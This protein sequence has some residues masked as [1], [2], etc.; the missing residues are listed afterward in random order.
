MRIRIIT[1][2]FT[3]ALDGTACFAE[4]RWE[5]SVLVQP[6][7]IATAQVVSLD[8]D[9]REYTPTLDHDAVANAAHAWRDADVLTLQFDSTLR[10][11]VARDCSTALAAS[12]RRKLLIAPAFPSAGRT[13]EEGCVLVDGVPVHETAFGYD[14][15]LPVRESSIPALLRAHGIEVKVARDAAQARALLD[16]HDAVVVDARTEAELDAIATTFAGARDLL[17]AGSTGLLRGL[18]R[19]LPRPQ[20]APDDRGN[21]GDHAA[22][23]VPLA[24]RPWLVVGSLNPRSRRQLSI[25]QAQCRVNVLATGET[26]LP[27]SAPPQAALRDLVVQAVNVV[28]S[29]A[30]DGLV[31]TGGE[32]ARRII[33]ALPVVSLRVCREI[34]PGVPLAEVQTAIGTF[35]MITKA[36]GF[37]DDDA[38][39]TCIYALTGAQP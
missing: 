15:T 17:L 34:M 33:D 3:S 11:R 5:T 16:V 27:A 35:P 24:G 13:V 39:L 12:G 14:P 4:R 21:C 32:T 38:L 6:E 9:S 30:C 20:S 31:V 2:D 19:V 7:G 28:S 8:T 36:G 10:G 22:S 29:R 1:D 23:R 18:A 26:R 37:G 25:A